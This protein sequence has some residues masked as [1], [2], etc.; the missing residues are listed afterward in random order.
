[1]DLARIEYE[2]NECGFAIVQDIGAPDEVIELK[3][4]SSYDDI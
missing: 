1:M 2:I 4:Q 3:K